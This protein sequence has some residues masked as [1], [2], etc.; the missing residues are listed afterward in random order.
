MNPNYKTGSRLRFC[1]FPRFQRSYLVR[2]EP[3]WSPVVTTQVGSL[4][5]PLE[6]QIS[7]EIIINIINCMATSL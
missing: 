6:T 3:V 4:L 1:L 2:A 7:S 5:V